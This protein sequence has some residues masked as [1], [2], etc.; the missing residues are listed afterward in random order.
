MATAQRQALIDQLTVNGSWKLS[1]T[2]P[3]PLSYRP[4]IIDVDREGWFSKKNCTKARVFPGQLYVWQPRGQPTQRNLTREKMCRVIRG[5]HILLVGDSIMDQFFIT[6]LQSMW[7]WPNGMPVRDFMQKYGTGPDRGI[8]AD[9]KTAHDIIGG[10]HPYVPGFYIPCPDGGHSQSHFRLSFIRNYYLSLTRKANRSNGTGV[11]QQ[12]WVPFLEQHRNSIVILNRGAHYVDDGPFAAELRDTFV[13]LRKH[14]ADALI[15]YRDTPIGHPEPY[16]YQQA[17]PLS[18]PLDSS[19][20]PL[21]MWQK[22]HYNSFDR[23][24]L[25]ARQIIAEAH[26]L[27][28]YMSVAASTNL[29]RDSHCDELHYCIPG[30]IDHW[31]A[32]L[33]DTLTVC[34][35]FE[36]KKQ[37]PER[38]GKTK[39]HFKNK[40][41]Q[42]K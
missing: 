29:R 37:K 33:L 14:H 21:N 25:L 35:S 22:Y 20:Y 28:V 27:A 42:S 4:Q 32:K 12:P 13:Y 19:R 15:I 31:V 23:Q 17:L 2:F 5:R 3:I 16:K 1:S 26:P 36:N 10:H 6:L 38:K 24:N 18:T 8:F 30:P 41:G 11:V 40:K 34:D 7:P 39:P 9:G